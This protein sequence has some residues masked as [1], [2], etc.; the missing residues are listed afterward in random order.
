MTYGSG[1]N[2]FLTITSPAIGVAFVE[3]DMHQPGIRK[4]TPVLIVRNILG[5]W[6]CQVVVNN[7]M[8]VGKRKLRQPR[9]IRVVGESPPPSGRG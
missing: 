4:P 7:M 6:G 5:E 3:P 2:W 1:D 8:R 9:E